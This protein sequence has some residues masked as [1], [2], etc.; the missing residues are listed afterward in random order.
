V[1]TARQEVRRQK[2]LHFLESKDPVWKNED[3]PELASGAGDWVRKLRTET[4]TR[5]AV[6]EKQERRARSR[7]PRLQNLRTR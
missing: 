2:L 6:W 1:E 7:R 3:H 4:E 5:G